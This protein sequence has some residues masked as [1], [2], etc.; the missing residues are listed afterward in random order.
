MKAAELNIETQ[1]LQ[2]EASQAQ[3]K[4]AKDA[5]DSYLD[6]Y[7]AEMN[8]QMEQLTHQMNLLQT[9]IA[10]AGKNNHQE[11]MA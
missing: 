9:I 7:K 3:N 5:T 10:H 6:K 2:L 8:L 1:R 11:N 4:A